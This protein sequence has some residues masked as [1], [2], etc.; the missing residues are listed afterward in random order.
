MLQ[1]VSNME[2]L[3]AIYAEFKS[4]DPS[5]DLPRI[6]DILGEAATLI[7]RSAEP[8]KW[9]AYRL[10]YAQRAQDVDPDAAIAA[11]RDSIPLWDSE[12]DR[13]PLLDCHYGLDR[14]S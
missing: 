3:A 5:Q 14:K 11:Y 7:D 1:G 12:H 8:K 2:R 13:T 9:A 10:M 4:P 6:L